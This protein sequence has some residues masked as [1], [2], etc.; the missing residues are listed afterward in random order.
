METTDYPLPRER[1]RWGN[2]PYVFRDTDDFHYQ[3]HWRLDE[4]FIAEWL[5]ISTTGLIT[6]KANQRGYAWD[7]CTPK[8]DILNLLIVGVPD[9]RIDYRT[10]KPYTYRASMV[11]DALYQ[12]LDTIPVPKREVDLLFFRM[13]GD[14]KLRRL[15]YWAVR[16]FGGLGVAQRGL[17]GEAA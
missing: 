14:F 1:M 8:A 5:E 11:H 3:T 9:G 17:L 7:G 13:L 10:G 15:Y 12:Y 2:F 16:L 6:V 4:P